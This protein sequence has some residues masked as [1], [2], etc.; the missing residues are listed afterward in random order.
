MRAVRPAKL[1]ICCVAKLSA[2]LS[3]RAEQKSGDLDGHLHLR[4]MGEPLQDLRLSQGDKVHG[5]ERV[6]SFTA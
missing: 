4:K 2:T 5:T 3:D 1:D 6:K